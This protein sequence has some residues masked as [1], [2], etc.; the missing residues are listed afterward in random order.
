MDE[1]SAKPTQED[2]LELFRRMPIAEKE[3]IIITQSR[4]IREQQGRID[5]LGRMAAGKAEKKKEKVS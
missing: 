3:L 4:I 1:Q 5:S 2:L